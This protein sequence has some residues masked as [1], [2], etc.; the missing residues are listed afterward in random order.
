MCQISR[1]A[2]GT[3]PPIFGR[4]ARHL[5]QLMTSLGAIQDTNYLLWKVAKAVRQPSGY[6]PL[7]CTATGT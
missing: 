1:R 7:I 4:T 5:K 6:S 3:F 2:R